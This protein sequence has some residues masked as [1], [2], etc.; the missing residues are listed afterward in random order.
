M[1]ILNVKDNSP[2]HIGKDITVIVERK[3]GQTR[4]MI[5][6]PEGVTILRDELYMPEYAKGSK[7]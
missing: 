5:S 1:L 2:V 3:H 6:A 7:L 4:L